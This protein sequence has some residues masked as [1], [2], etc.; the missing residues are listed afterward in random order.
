[1]PDNAAEVTAAGIARF[2]GVGRAAVSNWRRRH[3]DFPRPVGGSVSSPSFA[4]PEVEEWLRE[5]GKLSD[6]PLRERVWQQLRGH[7][8]GTATALRHAGA[9]LLLVQD[10]PEVS[11]RLAAGSDRQLAGLLPAAL[12]PVLFARLGPGHPVHTPDCA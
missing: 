3:S 8:A 12:G 1:M 5:Q 9:L 4:L 7:P 11:R 2:A 6:V 10:R